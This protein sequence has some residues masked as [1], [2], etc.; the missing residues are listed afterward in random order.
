MTQHGRLTAALSVEAPR[1]ASPHRPGGR[2]RLSGLTSMVVQSA[3][4][5]LPAGL[6]TS[7]E[8]D[9]SEA[10][11]PHVTPLRGG[12]AKGL[13]QEAAQTAR[14]VADL[15]EH[16][17]KARP[18]ARHSFGDVR[19]HTDP[20][21]AASAAGLSARA[22][23]VGPHIVFTTGQF[24]PGT[25][26]G[27]QVLAHELTH[28]L[29]QSG[30]GPGE[31]VAQCEEFGDNA[32]FESLPGPPPRALLLAP[33]RDEV[34][35]EEL[36]GD[37][38]APVEFAPD[39]ATVVMIDPDRLLDR[40]RPLF[41]GEPAPARNTWPFPGF[42]SRDARDYL[43]ER[44]AALAINLMLGRAV[45]TLDDDRII[46]APLS[47]FDDQDLDILPVVPPRDTREEAD[48]QVAEF[49]GTDTRGMTVVAFFRSDGLIWPTL[50]NPQT[51]PRV[52]SVYFQA[53]DAALADVRAT[54]GTFVDLLFWYIGARMLPGR[55][56][57]SGAQARLVIEGGR[58]LTAEEM[59]IVGRLLREGRSVRVLAESTR[60]GV[61]TAD[62]LVDG[63][64]TELKTISSLTSRDLSGAL[65]RRI[66]EG[67][68]QAPHII[69]DVRGQAGLTRELAE[70]AIRRAFGAD[71]LSRIQQIRVIGRDFDLIVPR[72]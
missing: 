14:R 32:R 33:Y 71:T 5:P 65:G 23:T 60:H 42:S 27:R 26:R 3:G 59:V 48:A 58:T 61:R 40:W 13:E 44:V 24:S 52:F 28:V 38:A 36:Y 29:Q 20:P 30:L 21:A 4:S 22:Y 39:D 63:V 45:I 8:A 66:L 72:I 25:P 12:R 64:R 67:A 46:E 16:P 11:A 15:P 35:A 68:G 53:R 19:V 2:G 57:G 47:W 51:A 37:P 49:A 18:T 55:G 7:L 69:A 34:I 54:E 41:G 6:R 10:T 62:F 43:D 56:T 50:I 70:R 9:L 17:V 1:A 31:Q